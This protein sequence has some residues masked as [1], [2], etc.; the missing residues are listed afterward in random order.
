M[1]DLI[2]TTQIEL[3]LISDQDARS[4]AA[5][6]IARSATHLAA[7]PLAPLAV[8]VERVRR[9]TVTAAGSSED[10]TYFKSRLKDCAEATEVDGRG[11]VIQPLECCDESLR[12]DLSRAASGQN[13]N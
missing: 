2:K 4:T 5:V 11:K 6:I 13:R 10:W 3:I 1:L 8:K 9:P 12:K 7:P